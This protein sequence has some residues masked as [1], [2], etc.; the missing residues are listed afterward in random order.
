M[1]KTLATRV[2]EARQHNRR[3]LTDLRFTL[4]QTSNH[5]Y[6]LSHDDKGGGGCGWSADYH[7]DVD[8]T[9]RT[10]LSGVEAGIAL[11]RRGVAVTTS[12]DRYTDAMERASE[13]WSD[14]IGALV[15]AGFVDAE[16]IQTGGM[17]LAISV[18]LPGVE[19]TAY[20][21]ITDYEE[22]LPWDRSTHEGY[23]VCVYPGECGDDITDEF[24]TVY[25]E[26]N[27]DPAPMIAAL[28][29]YVQRTAE[30]GDEV[31]P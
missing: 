28:L 24:D 25:V 27:T 14:V 10:Y 18:P 22:I 13:I 21:L 31:K 9:V 8:T 11:A 1:T 17:C 7:P 20:A 2:A 12:S 19:R 3:A 16:V 15:A 23:T 29:A 26:Q 5:A 4:T 30:G 6:E